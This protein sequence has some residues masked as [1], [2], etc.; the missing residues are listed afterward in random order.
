MSG[1]ARNLARNHGCAITVPGPDVDVVLEG[2]AHLV[3]NAA[4]LQQIADQFPAKYPWWHPVVNDGEFYDP[5][6]S[7]FSDPRHVYALEPA[8]VF[9]F[10]KEKGFT[11]TRWRGRSG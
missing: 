1:A 4:R 3:R 6:D 2:T 7:A 10:G 8:Q 9:A 11:A 5:A